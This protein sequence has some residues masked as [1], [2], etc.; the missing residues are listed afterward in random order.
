VL[1]GTNLASSQEA[2]ANEETT[3]E[4]AYKVG[5]KAIAQGA[6]VNLA[7]VTSV[8]EMPASEE[9]Y[10]DVIASMKDDL[11]IREG[12]ELPSKYDIR[13]K[14]VIDAAGEKVGITQ[15]DRYIDTIRELITGRREQFSEEEWDPTTNTIKGIKYTV[16]QDGNSKGQ[17]QYVDYTK[18]P[19]TGEI[20]TRNKERILNAAAAN[21]GMTAS[22]SMIYNNLFYL[23]GYGDLLNEMN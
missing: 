7:N 18:D 6:L 9:L 22:A 16:V 10:D 1:T 21:G 2:M 14:S 5:N 19:E 20:V 13:F 17:V 11:P 8:L 3:F 12:R 15:N 4:A 23:R